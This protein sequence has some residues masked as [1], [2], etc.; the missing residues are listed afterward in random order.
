MK[1]LAIGA[2]AIA[3]L[4]ASAAFAQNPAQSQVPA[5]PGPV[6]PGICSYSSQTLLRDSTAGQSVRTG[7][8]RLEQ[9]VQGELTPYQTAM[10][11]E[12]QA[13][14]QAGASLAANERQTR[15]EALQA[16]YQEFQQLGQQRQN[17]LRY[18]LSQ[19]LSQIEGAA[20]PIITALYQEKGCGVLLD[21]DSINYINP[22]MDF[23]ATAIQRLNQ[24]L[25]SL[26]FNRM[27][28]PAQTPGQ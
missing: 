1:T 12:A 22:A 16:R 23:T 7:M 21:R 8:Q 24:A 14:Q 3:S 4:A 26:S 20:G 18:T 17:D 28:A 5:N 11:S 2:F 9:E 13:L 6:I 19:Q 25:P 27:T 15:E 10:Q